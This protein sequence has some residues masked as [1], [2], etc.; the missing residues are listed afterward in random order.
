MVIGVVIASLVNYFMQSSA[1]QFVISVVGIL[2]FV[3][4]T[5]YDTQQIKEEYSANVGGE[6]VQ[7]MAVFG[8]FN[9][10]LNF[11]NIF[12]LLLNF[13]GERE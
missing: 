6:A 13:T 1:L 2:V 5:A 8:A 11:I 3:G 10:Y 4:L 12:M 7:K 9:L